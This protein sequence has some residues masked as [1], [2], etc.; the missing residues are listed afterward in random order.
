MKI[1]IFDS[2]LGGKLI[3]KAIRKKLPEYDY[4]F[5]GDTR[6][7]PY[8]DKTED[9]IY[10]LT[11]FAVEELFRRDCAL[12]ILAC[13]TASAESLRKLQDTILV[14]E[15]QGRRILGVIVPTVEEMIEGV[16]EQVLLI[17]TRRTVESGK[18][19]LELRK[20]DAGIVLTGIAT[21]E[22]VP[23]IEGDN[24]EAAHHY[25]VNLL[26][27]RGNGNMS[28][29]LGCTHYTALKAGLAREFPH[30]RIISQDGIVP[31]KLADYL[32]RHPEIRE[33]LSVKSKYKEIIT[34]K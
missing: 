19:E 16:H 31:K 13:N 15:W 20:R 22:L 4:L 23:L 27:T 3:A 28:L 6:N 24:L 10:E 2:G 9:E 1:G 21:P 29:V 5:Y 8:G 14:G 11:K 30:L 18:Y 25:V 17:G 33:K 26:R 32:K 12:V 7:L 34:K